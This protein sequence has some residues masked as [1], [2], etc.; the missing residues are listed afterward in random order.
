MIRK[1]VFNEIKGFPP[2]YRFAD[3]FDV[4]LKIA[5]AYPIA[6]VDE[7]LVFIRFH[8]ANTSHNRLGVRSDTYEILLKHYNP[9]RISVPIFLRTLSDHDISFG[10]AHLKAGNMTEAL[11]WFRRSVQRTP[12]RLR[13]WRYYLR[14]YIAHALHAKP[15]G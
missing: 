8:E 9:A 10:R 14:Y 6:Y 5:A 2:R 4:W 1:D 3:E 12:F 11:K 15:S 13:S 7:P